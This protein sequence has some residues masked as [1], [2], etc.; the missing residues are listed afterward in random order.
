MVDGVISEVS[1]VRNE[2]LRIGAQEGCEG[3]DLVQNYCMY[4]DHY[5]LSMK[6]NKKTIQAIYRKEWFGYRLVGC[7]SRIFQFHSTA[8]SLQVKLVSHYPDTVLASIYVDMNRAMFPLG[9]KR[10][11]DL[12]TYHI[13]WTSAAKHGHL[14]HFVPLLSKKV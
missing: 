8:N 7:Y 11:K 13:L 10:T 9:Y 6:L 5:N 4:S 3:L 2:C 14:N 12:R 1:Y